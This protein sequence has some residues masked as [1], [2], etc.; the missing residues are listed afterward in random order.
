MDGYDLL[1]VGVECSRMR[2]DQIMWDFEKHSK[3]VEKLID[4]NTDLDKCR[5]MT[6]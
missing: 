4:I 3:L 2:E 6:K 5:T 1:K